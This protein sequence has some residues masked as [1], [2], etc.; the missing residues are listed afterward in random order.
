[1]CSFSN[2]L[3]PRL[4]TAACQSNRI[5]ILCCLMIMQGEARLHSGPSNQST[6]MQH[7]LAD[8][9][10]PRESLLSRQL[11]EARVVNNILMQVR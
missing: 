1:M 4:F 10:S 11:E 9:P 5:M 3:E 8:A 2:A 6:Q 7:Q